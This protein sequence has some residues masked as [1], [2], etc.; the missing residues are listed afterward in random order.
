MIRD[1][2]GLVTIN[3]PNFIWAFGASELMRV[4]RYNL[5][6]I[7]NFHP[8]VNN[9]GGG[10][11]PSTEVIWDTLLSNGKKVYG[12]A[13][14]D[15]HYIQVFSPKHANPGRGWVW[16]QCDELTPGNIITALSQGNFYFSSGVEL[17]D[18]R[19]DD[20]SL[21]IE[22]NPVQ[23]TKYTVEFIGKGGNVLSVQYQPRSVYT[24]TG[25]ETYVRAKIIDS[26]GFCAWTQPVFLDER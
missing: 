15:E 12:L 2:G 13:C 17:K 11:M 9:Y 5:L 1:A 24:F 21:T 23:N 26:N 6:E 14:D 16:V 4:E 22:I 7:H 19:A 8:Q 25:D 10:G 20:T 18:I 3:H